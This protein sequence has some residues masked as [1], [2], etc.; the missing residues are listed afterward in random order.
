MGKEDEAALR[1]WSEVDLCSLLWCL[2]PIGSPGAVLIG[3]RMSSALHRYPMGYSP[4][5]LCLGLGPFS[6]G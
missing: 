6:P 2:L 4:A 3:W 5:A 1:S